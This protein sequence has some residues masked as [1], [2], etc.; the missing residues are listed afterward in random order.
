MLHFAGD[1][2]QLATLVTPNGRLASTV[3]LG[4]DQLDRL[5]ITVITIMANPVTTTLA[6]VAD[7]VTTGTIRVPVARTYRLDEVPEALADFSAGKCGKL[8]VRIEG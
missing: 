3:G 2:A 5:D 6:Q 8:A 1:G 7:A 4:G